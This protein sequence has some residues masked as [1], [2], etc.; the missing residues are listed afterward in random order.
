MQIRFILFFF[1]F[2][3]SKT[4]NL[5]HKNRNNVTITIKNIRENVE[6]FNRKCKCLQK[7]VQLLVEIF[8]FI[9]LREDARFLE[10]TL[11]CN[12]CRGFY[13]VE[14]DNIYRNLF[15]FLQLLK[16]IQNY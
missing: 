3:N 15:K 13:T 2:R 9:Y 16:I 4:K 11:N 5:F 7:N 8:I 10:K 12:I 14:N 6:L 1:L